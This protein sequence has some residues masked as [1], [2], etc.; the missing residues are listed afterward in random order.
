MH[1]LPNIRKIFIPDPGYVIGDADLS[2]ADAQVV[3]WEAQD[4]MLMEAFRKG[5]KVHILN[6]RTMFPEKV[7]GWSDEAIKASPLYEQNKRAVHATNYGGSG[8]TIAM[9]NGW[10]V[11]EGEAFQRRWFG[12]H[13]GI[14]SW[15]NRTEQTL[16][17]TRTITNVFGYRKVYFDR[18]DGL[19]PQALAWVPQSTVAI[20][21]FRGLLNARRILPWVEFLIQVHD[22]LVFQLRFHMM[23]EL[24]RLRDA[25]H[26]PIPYES[27]LLIPWGLSISPT[28]WGDCVARG[29]EE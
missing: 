9:T 5:L 3:A 4:E 7:R 15:H 27:P 8:K 16:T 28:S 10:L 6:C 13:P 22:S 12:E 29:W 14:K 1:K 21:C 11:S 24:R 2:G 23:K 19:L 20:V 26:I 17:R 25:L 18:V